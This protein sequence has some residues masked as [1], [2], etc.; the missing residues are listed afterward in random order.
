MYKKIAGKFLKNPDVKRFVNRVIEELGYNVGYMR[1]LP[2]KYYATLQAFEVDVVDSNGFSQNQKLKMLENGSI[3]KITEQKLIEFLSKKGIEIPEL[4]LEYGQVS[5]DIVNIGREEYL[6][7]DQRRARAGKSP[8]ITLIKPTT[9]TSEE[10]INAILE[11]R[12]YILDYEDDQE[13]FLGLGKKGRERRR[14]RREDRHRRKIERRNNRTNRKIAK[15]EARNEGRLDRTSVKQQAKA[16]NNLGTSLTGREGAKSGASNII[17]SI[18][19]S[20]VIGQ[21]G[22]ALGGLFGGGGAIPNQSDNTRFNGM[23]NNAINT[24]KDVDGVQDPK[25]IAGFDTNMLLVLGVGGAVIYMLMK[26]K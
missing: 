18:G 9:T 12:N 11:R 19:Q 25:T 23:N 8:L 15:I 26:A 4:L 20:G 6:V 7:A 22:G 5:A 21:L 14:K 1:T 2:G 3:D 16:L 13:Y 10:V 24:L 17:S